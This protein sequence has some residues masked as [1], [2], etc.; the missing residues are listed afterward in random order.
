MGEQG[1][2]VTVCGTREGN[3]DESTYSGYIIEASRRPQNTGEKVRPFGLSPVMKR[4]V[5]K[6]DFAI[7]KIEGSFAAEMTIA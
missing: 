2:A 4:S 6:E 3:C 5:L 7:P 1:S